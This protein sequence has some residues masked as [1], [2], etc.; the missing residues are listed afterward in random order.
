MGRVR[1]YESNAERQAAY[2]ARQLESMGLSPRSRVAAGRASSGSVSEYLPGL[3]S[4][5]GCPV[6]T[7]D[8]LLRGLRVVVD[9]LDPASRCSLSQA[10][11]K[12]SGRY[13]GWNVES[14][15]RLRVDPA[16]SEEL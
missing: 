4:A 2:R 5:I 16:C 8:E 12:A 6:L 1:Q 11:A 7:D 15:C 13:S 9:L 3:K 14:H 10:V